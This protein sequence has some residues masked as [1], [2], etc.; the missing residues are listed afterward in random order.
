MHR[1]V[2]R[3]CASFSAVAGV[4]AVSGIVPSGLSSIDHASAVYAEG[5]ETPAAAA[6]RQFMHAREVHDGQ[7]MYGLWSLEGR[8]MMP[9][10]PFK[11]GEAVKGMLAAT[12]PMPEAF[13]L[14]AM[15]FIDVQ[16]SSHYT[17]K[18]VGIDPKDPT[19]FL[20]DGSPE[21]ATTP[22]SLR[23]FTMKDTDG[24]VHLDLM[25]TATT[26][27]PP[28]L[29]AR[30]TAKD[31]TCVS[32]VKQICLGI[33]QYVQDN[34]QRFPDADKWVDEV[35]PYIKSMQVF[36]DPQDKPDSK[37][38]YAYN[39]ALSGKKMTDIASP[40]DTVLIFD[41][42]LETKNASDKGESIPKPGRHQGKTVIGFTDGH[43][44]Q[45]DDDKLPAIHG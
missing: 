18:F 43:V 32:N 9:Y 21:G 36:Q 10:A 16:N 13:K 2:W 4:F 1:N 14:V 39:R 45:V 24:H 6:V 22:M 12:P 17:Y 19:V 34:D 11:S 15:F 8:K 20:V 44:S 30:E 38:S 42:N 5:A 29:K 7:T 37:W 33:V 26:A 27:Y 35:Y 25:K 41:S 40:A 28:L 3:A 23:V 31:T